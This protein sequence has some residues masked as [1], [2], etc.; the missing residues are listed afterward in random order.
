MIN[1]YW[2]KCQTITENVLSFSSNA[3]VESSSVSCE[4]T[5]QV[6]QLSSLLLILSRFAAKLISGV[7]DFKTIIDK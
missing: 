7:L 3:M 6:K 5:L 4:F 2:K 1:R